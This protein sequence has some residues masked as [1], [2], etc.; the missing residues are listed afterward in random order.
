MACPAIT[1]KGGAL[2]VSPSPVGHDTLAD[3]ILS[4]ANVRVPG[5][6]S[7]GDTGIEQDTGTYPVYSSH[8]SASF[9]GD[10][11]GITW[12]IEIL[13]QQS[14]GREILENAARPENNN[15]YAAMIVW[16][17]GEIEVSTNL[18]HSPNY[19]KGLGSG[20]RAVS[21]SLSPASRP[22]RIPPTIVSNEDVIV[23]F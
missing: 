4:I 22:V 2:Y 20:V 11:R 1:N 12:D 6:G 16:P 3:D 14:T 15:T 21:Y 9:K 8:Y 10:A 7:I 18:V 17:D 5:V 23:V 13:D 19:I